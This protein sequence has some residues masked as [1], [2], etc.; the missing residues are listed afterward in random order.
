M[1]NSKNNIFKSYSDGPV[2]L[3]DLS[4][5]DC[6]DG[7]TL[8]VPSPHNLEA[9]MLAAVCSDES[10]TDWCIE[11]ATRINSYQYLIFRSITRDN[12]VAILTS[13]RHKREMSRPIY[14]RSNISNIE[15][16]VG[17]YFTIDFQ[18]N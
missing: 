1:N 3:V 14:A 6:D 7:F 9:V 4:Y 8:V 2:K 12:D 18:G 13:G 16:C 15:L 17:C 11:I 5:P 10:I